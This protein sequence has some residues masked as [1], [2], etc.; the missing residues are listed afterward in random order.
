M[1][2]ELITPVLI[3]NSIVSIYKREAI[4]LRNK[5]ASAPYFPSALSLKLIVVML[6]VFPRVLC[7]EGAHPHIFLILG[8]GRILLR[9][10]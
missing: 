4:Q 8:L 5:G 10:L 1:P 7:L 3:A 2:L 9:S 6:G